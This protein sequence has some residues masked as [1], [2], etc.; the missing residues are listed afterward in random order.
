MKISVAT[1]TK[2]RRAWLPK[3]IRSVQAQS[4]QDWQHVIFDV[5]HP[6]IRDLVPD[7]PRFVY[8]HG[9]PMGVAVDHQR[10]Q[11]LGDGE[12]CCFLSDDDML[13]PNALE[14]VSREIGDNP[15]LLAKT[16]LVNDTGGVIC[17]RG[18]DQE[19]VYATLSGQY[20][21]GGAIFARRDFREQVGG[22]RAEYEGA[23][24]FDLYLRFLKAAPPIIIPDVLYCYVDHP[25]TDSN[26]N[27]AQQRATTERIARQL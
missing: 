11:D 22:L 19:S 2:D 26:V 15:W 27:A 14:V 16:V 23:P 5:S 4:Y 17:Y 10:A 20:M 9:E 18:G 21:L 6:P 1:P 13:T 12:V 3:A 25:D 7:D 8:A 24:D